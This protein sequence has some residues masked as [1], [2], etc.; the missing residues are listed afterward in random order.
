M[1]PAL[2]F[3]AF[4]I[5]IIQQVVGWKVISVK[6][7][8]VFFNFRLKQLSA[9]K[10]SDIQ[11][12]NKPDDNRKEVEDL[13]KLV[14][15]IIKAV[16]E[17]READLEKAGMRVSKRP[18]KDVI[19]ENMKDERINAQILGVA[20]A[21]QI[22]IMKAID[23]SMKSDSLLS[24]NGYDDTETAE[25]LSSDELSEIITEAE[26]NIRKFRESGQTFTRILE[27]DNFDFDSWSLENQDYGVESI[28]TP[29]IDIFDESPPTPVGGSYLEIEEWDES[30][31][32]TG[33]A[34]E[35]DDMSSTKGSTTV[36]I[37]ESIQSTGVTRK[38]GFNYKQNQKRLHR[39]L[40]ISRL[41]EVPTANDTSELPE[42]GYFAEKQSL[43]PDPVPTTPE[44]TPA[45]PSPVV[46]PIERASSFA[47]EQTFQSLLKVTMDDAT[48]P[49]DLS[50]QV[51]GTT[52]QSIQSGDFAVLDVKTLIG[53]TLSALTSELGIDMGQELSDSQSQEIMR[54]IVGS[55]MAELAQNMAELESESQGLYNQLSSLQAALKD[56]TEQFEERKQDELEELLTQQKS[57]TSDYVRS[58][59]NLKATSE[60]LRDSLVNLENSADFIT[61]L[62]L[63]PLKS[64]DKKIAFVIGLALLLKVPF[65]MVSLFQIRSSDFTDWFTIFTQFTLCLTLFSHYGLVKAL[66]NPRLK[67]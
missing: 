66:L 14:G 47:V 57:L 15:H 3:V 61:A 19:N 16:D 25:Y 53:E 30:I 67:L 27:S 5:I 60:Q 42:S 59:T 26:E 32:N 37:N 46:D 10:Q 9:T 12:D 41:D 50:E 20:D 36:P 29:L 13:A 31:Y 6:Q 23:L 2:F 35:E 56:E 1:K 8:N 62:A 11:T 44:S 55:S 7:M 49:R 38:Y 17:G 52:V 39:E 33:I 51:V 22:E 65:D 4:F 58:Q 21:E 48:V 24:I 28:L 45:S 34:T 18:V 43:S 63:F 40:P 54:K 64:N